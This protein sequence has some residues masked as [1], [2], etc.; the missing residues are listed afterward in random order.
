MRR[1]MIAVALA[2]GAL[3]WTGSARAEGTQQ[4]TSSDQ[5]AQNQT[6][7][8]RAADRNMTNAT[9]GSA[10]RRDAKEEPKSR[11]EGKSNFDVKGKIASVSGNALTLRRDDDKLPPVTLHVAGDTKVTLGGDHAS[12]SQLQAGEDVKASFNLEGDKP[13]AVEVKADK[14]KNDGNA[15]RK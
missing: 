14:P 4:K 13:I 3:A 2:A 6:R 11:F 5:A 12:L 1:Q 7:A 15:N 10:E 8:E 9:A